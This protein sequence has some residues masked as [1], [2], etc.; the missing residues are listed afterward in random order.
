MIFHRPDESAQEEGFQV[1]CFGM[2]EK[3]LIRQSRRDKKRTAHPSGEQPHD[4]FQIIFRSEI[5]DFPETFHHDLAQPPVGET[6]FR[7]SLAV[8]HYE[9]LMRSASAVSPADR[10]K[11]RPEGKQTQRIHTAFFHCG[12]ILFDPAFRPFMPHAGSVFAR[13]VIAADQK[14]LCSGQIFH[15]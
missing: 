10:L 5:A 7:K 8:R 12:K 1:K 15:K 6:F 13:P 2:R 4:Q 3:V 14:I 9:F 11:I